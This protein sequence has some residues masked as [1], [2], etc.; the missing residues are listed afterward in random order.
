MHINPAI[1]TYLTGR[2]NQALAT[3]Q[4]SQPVFKR[5]FDQ[6]QTIDTEQVRQN[7]HNELVANCENHWIHAEELMRGILFEYDYIF[8]ENEHAAAYG[9]TFGDFKAQAEPYGFG[10]F[11]QFADGFEALPGITLSLSNPL[12]VIER[13]R[14][15]ANLPD[16]EL[17]YYTG[18]PRGYTELIDAYTFTAFICLHHALADLSQTPTFN[19]LSRRSPFY[20]LIDQHDMGDAYPVYVTG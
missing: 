13:E 19:A 6:L 7:F 10:N 17:E 16:D 1:L 11:T 12:S 9:V 14:F 8:R 3:F 20:F 2:R 18:N 15:E 5:L 4:S